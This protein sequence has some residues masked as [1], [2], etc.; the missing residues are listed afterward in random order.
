MNETPESDENRSEP[1]DPESSETD[2]SRR[3]HL[4]EIEDGCG[5]AEVWEH[6][7]EHRRTT[8]D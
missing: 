8:D 7:S 6:L 4:S 5:C 3:T 1:E 2:E